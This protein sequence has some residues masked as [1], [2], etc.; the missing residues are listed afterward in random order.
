MLKDI[1]KRFPEIVRKFNQLEESYAP[2]PSPCRKKALREKGIALE[3]DIQ[4]MNQDKLPAEF[5]QSVFDQEE[6][7]TFF[8]EYP[9]LS[10]FCEDMC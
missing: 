3:M 7:A 2:R 10:S 4:F 1:N 8:V 6:S 9:T 5:Q